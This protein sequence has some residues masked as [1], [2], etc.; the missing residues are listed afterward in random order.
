ME[1]PAHQVLIAA[2]MSLR[3]YARPQAPKSDI[4]EAVLTKSSL[5]WVVR[6]KNGKR[7]APYGVGDPVSPPGS[8]APVRD[9][10]RRALDSGDLT[11]GEAR[12][13]SILP[14]F[15]DIPPVAFPTKNGIVGSMISRVPPL[16][17]RLDRRWF[18]S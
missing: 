12:V 18:S 16:R 17:I 9:T 5:E 2:F 11:A 7:V 4:D 1:S 6:D 3:R 10:H 13:D 15:Q 8:G 14:F